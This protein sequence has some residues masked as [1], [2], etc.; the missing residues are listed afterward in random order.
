MPP[1]PGPRAGCLAG[2][3]ARAWEDGPRGTELVL[4]GARLCIEVILSSRGPFLPVDAP[5][6]SS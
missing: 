5:K 4:S 6:L 1:E 3:S 2:T